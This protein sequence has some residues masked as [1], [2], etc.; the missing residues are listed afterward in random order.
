MKTQHPY[1]TV[2]FENDGSVSMRPS[3]WVTKDRC[4]SHF[5]L[6]KGQIQWCEAEAAQASS[7]I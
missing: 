4:G 3:F 2:K 6:W 1:W 7:F 5:I